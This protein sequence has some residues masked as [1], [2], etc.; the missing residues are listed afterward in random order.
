MIYIYIQYSQGLPIY[1]PHW[2]FWLYIP[3]GS[4]LYGSNCVFAF[5][6]FHIVLNLISCLVFLH[7]PLP[8]GMGPLTPAD[9]NWKRLSEGQLQQHY[10]FGYTVGLPGWSWEDANHMDQNVRPGTLGRTVVAV[11]QSFLWARDLS[12][13]GSAILATEYVYTYI[14]IS[15][16]ITCSEQVPSK[17][18]DSRHLCVK[19]D[20]AWAT[21]NYCSFELI[22][23]IT[24][25]SSTFPPQS[26]SSVCMSKPRSSPE[27]YR[28]SPKG[29]PI[30]ICGRQF[31]SSVA[32]L[33]LD[34]SYIQAKKSH[35]KDFNEVVVAYN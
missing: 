19:I 9:S 6:Y 21:M 15:K 13:N 24:S 29:W 5:S 4:S 2:Q 27:R 31:R 3:F 22:G 14:Y 10:S 16:H 28:T 30:Q 8:H 23:I 20:I 12:Q 34:E 26:E 17:E 33:P 35:K 18:T 1:Q 11:T 32:T 7:P 25:R